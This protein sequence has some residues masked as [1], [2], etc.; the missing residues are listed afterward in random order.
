MQTANEHYFNS[1][2]EDYNI[3]FAD[4]IIFISHKM[5]GEYTEVEVKISDWY[6]SICAKLNNMLAELSPC[7]Q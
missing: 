6:A 2:Q 1:I 3:V 4:Y 5:R 7:Q